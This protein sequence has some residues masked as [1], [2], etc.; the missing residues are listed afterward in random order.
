LNDLS[1]GVEHAAAFTSYCKDHGERLGLGDI[2]F[3]VQVLT[4]GYWPT[5]KQVDMTLPQNM[6]KCIHVFSQYYEHQTTHR[7]LSWQYSLGN[8][9]VKALF[10]KKSYELQ[11]TTLQAAVLM[12][13][14]EE[15]VRDF[16]ALQSI[17]GIDPEYLKRALHSLAC[18]KYRVLKKASTTTSSDAAANAKAEKVV[19]ST[20]IFHFNDSFTCPMRKL[21]IPMASLEDNNSNKRIEEDRTVV[22][23]AAIV[24]IMKS[25]KTLGHQQL[26]AEVMT[27]LTFFKPEVKTVKL[28]IENLIEREYL[29]RDADNS[30]VYK[31]LA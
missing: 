21:R 20:D 29:E 19:S 11:I 16:N 14:N 30:S 24:R 23:E 28:R 2:E 5:F 8:A 31:Y 9:S 15:G 7:K 4:S 10:N 13:F 12:A 25:R 1:I 17:T 6:Q 18:G 3:S 22:I 26:L 27:Q